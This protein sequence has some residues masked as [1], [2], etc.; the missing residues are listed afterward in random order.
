MEDLVI[1]NARIVDGTGA[2]SFFGDVA[3]KDGV[4]TQ[5]GGKA[6]TARREIAADG[7]LVT[8]GFID[9][10]THYDGQVM[11]DKGLAQSGWHGVTSAVMGNC[12]VGFAPVRPEHRD[13]IIDLMEGIED[14]P[15]PSL[16]AGLPWTWSTFPEFMDVLA[17]GQYGVDI[18][19]Q[20][21][22]AV[23]R[24]YAM[25]ER[26]ADNQP[27]TSDDIAAMAALVKE[28]MHAGALGLTMTRSINHRSVDG[29]NAPGYDVTAEEPLALARAVG[30][31]G[32]GVLGFN[33]DFDD[34]DADIALLRRVRRESGRTVWVLVNQQLH[35]PDRWKAIMAGIE[36]ANAEGEPIVAQVAGRPVSILL[37]LT[38]SRSPIFEKPS[39][40]AIA[41]LP[42][43]QR[44]A[45]LRDPAF[46][47][48]ILAEQSG[49]STEVNKL[50]GTR[51]DRMFR[52][53]DP[54]DYEPLPESSIAAIAAREGRRP[55]EVAYDMMLERDGR[56]LFFMPAANY[57]SGDASLVMHFL[58][59]PNTVLGLGDGGA[60]IS[61]ICDTSNPTYMLTH[62]A[63]DRKRG[64]TIPLEQ[65]VK[66]QTG[67]A[68][69]FY[70]LGDR[71]VLAVGKKADLNIIDHAALHLHAPEMRY[72][73][74]AGAPRLVQ[75]ADG[76]IATILSGVPVHENGEATGDLPGRL[77][78]GAR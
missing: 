62:W 36:R 43:D 30:E 78:R 34:V 58:Q 65:V 74:P 72:D 41:H 29:R 23:L 71:G 45:R 24:T 5:V 66:F 68:A 4:L 13:R 46:R 28:G 39:Y 12:G 35:I 76:Y 11:W 64:P 25:G 55:E 42:L 52:L 33:L 18:G 59:H 56:E 3:V 44:V 6:G 2:A 26:G 32:R 31:T 17:A 54:P 61:R 49:Y 50:Y 19:A 37:G 57:A 77:I 47:Q 8:P 1:R 21:P 10:H 63:R 16:R 48:K 69:A 53:G 7:A 73:Q 14:I 9:I 20:L 67:D 27:A 15:G 60:H 38:S 51:F 40:K 22:Y 70:G 75:R